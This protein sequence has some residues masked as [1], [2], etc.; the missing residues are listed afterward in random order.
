MR[1]IREWLWGLLPDNCEVVGCCRKGMR[2]NENLL[3]MFPLVDVIAC[4]YC[5]MRQHRGE[6]LKGRW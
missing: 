3:T 5:T 2:G 1:R 4:D 6:H